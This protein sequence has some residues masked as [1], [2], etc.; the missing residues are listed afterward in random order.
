MPL[1][2]N[3]C[4]YTSATTGLWFSAAHGR[5]SKA[6]PVV[7]LQSECRA[8]PWLGR[9]LSPPPPQQ[10][11]LTAQQ[12]LS[13][14]KWVPRGRSQGFNYNTTVFWLATITFFLKGLSKLDGTQYITSI[15]NLAYAMSAY[16]ISV[17]QWQ[18]CNKVIVHFTF[19]AFPV[20]M[21]K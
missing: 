18:N 21:W 9:N 19:Q 13:K 11:W 7:T 20:S 3:L 2:K 1:D 14:P 6:R 10:L 5:Y 15:T 12:T 17:V 16:A 8:T 4:H